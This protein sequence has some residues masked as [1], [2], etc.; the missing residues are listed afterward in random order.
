MPTIEIG[1]RAR[2]PVEENASAPRA[3]NSEVYVENKGGIRRT[4]ASA[5][6]EL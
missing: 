4:W 1:I 5:T 3:A 2:N 6:V